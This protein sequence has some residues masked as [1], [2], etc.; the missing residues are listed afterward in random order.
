LQ[1]GQLEN[2][3]K[4]KS[5]IGY[6]KKDFDEYQRSKTET[7]SMIKWLQTVINVRNA[8]EIQL[9]ID[10]PDVGS[11]AVEEQTFPVDWSQL[12]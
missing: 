2:T 5:R 10:I 1:T 8:E 7:L 4:I 9:S 6:E 12:L 3:R 11:N